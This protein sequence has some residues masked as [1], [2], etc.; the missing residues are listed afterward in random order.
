MNF[1]N[2]WIRD[3]KTPKAKDKRRYVIAG[4][5]IVGG[6]ILIPFTYGVSLILVGIGVVKIKNALTDDT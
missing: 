1:V 3:A 2:D 6:V 5:C 4:A